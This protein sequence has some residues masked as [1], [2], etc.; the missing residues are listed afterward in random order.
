MR[1]KGYVGPIDW[2]AISQRKSE[3]LVIDGADLRGE[4]LAEL[5]LVKSS[6][7]TAHLEG[8]SLYQADLE[9]ADFVGAH[10]GGANLGGADL[11]GAFFD[12]ATSLV[13]ITLS[14]NA[15][16]TVSICD[17]HWGDVNVS[18]VDWSTI[19]ILGEENEAKTDT[20][21]LPEFNY[22]KAAR[23]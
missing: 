11:S 15:H 21:V 20:T 22:E 2:N 18:V 10:L 19:S 16:G 17:I 4:K 13:D 14:T 23:A 12:S 3:G 7:V 1:V 6:L 9:Q 5:P 8:T